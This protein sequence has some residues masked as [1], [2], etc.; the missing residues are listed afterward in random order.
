MGKRIVKKVRSDFCNGDF[1]LA[2]MIWSLQ[3]SSV[4][5]YQRGNQKTLK[6]RNGETKIDKKKS[7]KHG[8][9]NIVQTTKD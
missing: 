2:I 3:P 4:L 8:L 1:F 6:R 7:I 5:G 9:L